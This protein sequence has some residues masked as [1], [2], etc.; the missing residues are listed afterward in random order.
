MVGCATKAPSF[1][2][3]V[4][5]EGKAVADIGEKWGRGQELIR[6]CNKRIRKGNEQIEDGN[7]NIA[8]G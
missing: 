6:K 3:S 2:E 7:E 4:Q 1:G 5:A 8:E